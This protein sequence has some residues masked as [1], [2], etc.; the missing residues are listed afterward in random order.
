M[1]LMFWDDVVP[2]W[3]WSLVHSHVLS[4]VLPRVLWRAICLWG[5]TQNALCTVF[6]FLC[7]CSLRVALTAWQNMLAHNMPLQHQGYFE[8]KALEKQKMQKE[9]SHFPFFLKM[10]DEIPCKSCPPYTRRKVTF[11]SRK[12][13]Q[14]QENSIRTDLVK[15][16]LIFLSPSCNTGC[17]SLSHFF[18]SSFPFEGS[19]VM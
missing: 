11:L 13:S 5:Y 17:S 19:H 2:N 3:L 8:R 6:Y 9:H 16:V 4:A 18:G 12:G 14:G 7:S 10:G 1:L 15:I